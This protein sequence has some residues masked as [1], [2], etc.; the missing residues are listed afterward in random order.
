VKSRCVLLSV[1]LLVASSPGSAQTGDPSQLTLQHIFASPEF[2]PERFGPARWLEDGSGYTTLEQSE[3]SQGG[4]DIVR[5]DPATNRRELWVPAARLVPLGETRALDIADYHWSD[6]GTKLLI[7]TNTERVWRSNTRGDYWVL[8]LRGWELTKLGGNAAPS[9]LMFA[10]FSPDGTQA[11][12]VREN[13]IYVEDLATGAITQL[14]S[15]GS[16]TIVNGTSDWVYEEEFFLRDGFRWSP[17]GSAI[18]Y[19]QFDTEGVNEFTMINNTDSLYPSL[20][21]FPY[22]KAGEMNSAVRVG[23]VSATG[24]A[25]V[26]MR[27][28]TDPRD[29]YIPRMEWAANSDHVVIQHLNRL[30]NT[31]RLLLGNATTGEITTV[32]VERDDAWLDVVE[33]LHW[34]D[35]GREFT[36]VSER[37]GWRHLY[38]VSRDGSTVRPITPGAYDVVRVQTI[39]EES[40]WVYFIASPENPNQRYLFRVRLDGSGTPERLSPTDQPGTH[41]YQISP[42]ADWAIHSYSRFGVPPITNLIRLPGHAVARPLVQNERLRQRVSAIERGD[43]EFFRVDNGEGVPLDVFLMT[44]PDFDSASAYPVLFYVYGEPWGQTVADRW[45]GSSYL[46][47]TMLTQQGYLVASV[48]NRGTPAPRGRDWRKVVYR[49]I[50]VH[51]SADQAAAL[52]AISGRPYV[53]ASRV[54]I[55]GWS[56][57]GSM[58]LN[59]IFRYPDLYHTAMAVAPVPDIRLYDTIYQERYMGLPRQNPRDYEQASPVTYAHQLKGNLLVVH[60]TGDD[61]VHY[62]GTERLINE[63]VAH[64]KQFTMMAYPN[65]SHGIFEGRGTTL[66]LFTLLTDYLKTN[67]PAGPSTPAMTP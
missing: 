56:G 42:G 46:W 55:W 65:R 48:D 67:L 59:M 39:D 18:A 64:G 34:L 57:G 27:I 29:N 20:V 19:W 22:P 3:S 6:D 62:Q 11:G 7:F 14:T 12:Y 43:V 32:L 23:V 40:G 28:E 41:S 16:A 58:S 26:W 49:K 53:D 15:D 50:G 44:P 1:F 30:Q 36:W 5:Y 51:A 17:D 21:T 35:D 45:G 9:T 61:N 25:T 47:H 24:G 2:F 33:D 38:R 63:L 60:G 37:D 31:N 66:H 54:G 52:R 10:K 8:N 4:R 13:N